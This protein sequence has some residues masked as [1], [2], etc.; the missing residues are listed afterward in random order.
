MECH[1]R[2]VCLQSKFNIRPICQLNDK[3]NFKVLTMNSSVSLK[4]AYTQHLWKLLETTNMTATK[5][6]LHYKMKA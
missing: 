4:V 1:T 5:S 6:A 2:N 3:F